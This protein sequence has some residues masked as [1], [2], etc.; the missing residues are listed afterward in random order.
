MPTIRTPFWWLAGIGL[1]ALAGYLDLHSTEVQTPAAFVVFAAGALGFVHPRH[2]WQWALFVGM[3]IPA[4]HWLID[5]LGMTQPYA[6]MPWYSMVILPLLFA[7]VAA[8]TGAGL[9]NI[10][11]ASA[12]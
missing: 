6:I 4:A 12:V 3:G 5:A 10:I 2:A 8:Y 7:L 1:G 9:R 11:R